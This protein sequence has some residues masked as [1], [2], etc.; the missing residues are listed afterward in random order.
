LIKPALAMD[1]ESARTLTTVAAAKENDFG[2]MNP[3]FE[4]RHDLDSRSSQAR[5]LSKIK[6]ENQKL[7]QINKLG[8]IHDWR[9]GGLS[10]LAVN[11][12]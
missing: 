8:K 9:N 12:R 2:I 10:T 3:G 11:I 1:V 5:L 7:I 6:A 4:F